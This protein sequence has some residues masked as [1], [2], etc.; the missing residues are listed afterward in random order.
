MKF[1]PI[2]ITRDWLHEARG[3]VVRFPG[4]LTLLTHEAYRQREKNA[5]QIGRDYQHGL[6]RQ[7]VQPLTTALAR[8]GA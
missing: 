5:F 2:Q 7:S 3:G 8:K 6:D 1:H 4:R